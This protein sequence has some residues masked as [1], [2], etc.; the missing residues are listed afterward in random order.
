V[1]EGD[2]VALIGPNGAGKTTVFNVLTGLYAPSAGT[3]RFAGEPLLGLAPHEIVA[4]GVART[5]QNTE[6]FRRL[7]VRDNVLV[8]LHSRLAGGVL[9]GAF[10]R[11]RVRREERDARRRA[12]ELLARLGLTDVA[13]LE[14]G[15]LPLG[16]QKRLELARALASEPRLLLLDEPA[17]GLN[18]TETQALMD[19]IVR[20]RADEAL[21][22]LL[23]EHDMALVMGVSDAIA[24]LH[25][26]RK[27]AQGTPREVATNP[28][29]VEAYLGAEDDA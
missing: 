29:V 4:R 27:I 15:S 6:V 21:T 24:V 5:F 20:L 3:V 19:V 25:H 18:P 2:I 10:A 16:R 12:D 7:S 26:G 22:I 8:G 1:R 28:A 14:A 11:P 13:D 23:V 17:G 9:G